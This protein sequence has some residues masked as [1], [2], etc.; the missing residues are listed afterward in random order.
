V[1]TQQRL[2]DACPRI[3]PQPTQ[4]TRPAEIRGGACVKVFLAM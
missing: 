3:T 1:L 2:N 4:Q